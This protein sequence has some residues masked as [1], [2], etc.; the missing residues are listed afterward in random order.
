MPEAN[1]LRLDVFPLL[2]AVADVSF[3]ITRAIVMVAMIVVQRML[4]LNLGALFSI[5]HN[6]QFVWL[7][8]ADIGYLVCIIER[9]DER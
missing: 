3:L 2:A 7:E 1:R 6:V 5:D 8:A 4:G 9:Q